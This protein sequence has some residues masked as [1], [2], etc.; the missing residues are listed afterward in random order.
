MRMKILLLIFSIFFIGS[1]TFVSAQ[2]DP[3]CKVEIQGGSGKMYSGQNAYLLAVVKGSTPLSYL[4][5][6]EGDIIKNYDDNVLG[7]SHD[8]IV[9]PPTPMSVE[10]FLNPSISFYWKPTDDKERT[11]SLVV[12]TSN[13]ECKTDRIINVEL[14]KDAKTQPEDFYVAQNH[15]LPGDTTN[16]LNQH[17][18]W[19]SEYR[20]WDE[21]YNDNGDLF[22]DFHRIY[23]EHFDAWRKEF[24]Y[25]NITIWDPGTPLPYGSDVD[26][27]SRGPNYIPN[28][29]PTWFKVQPSGDGPKDRDSTS[30]TCEEFDKPVSPWPSTQDAL[31]D[32]DPDLELLGCALTDPYHNDVHV[33]IDGDMGSTNAAPLD[34][35]FWRWHKFV[36]NIAVERGSLPQIN[37]FISPGGV[38]ANESSPPRIYYQNPF[39]LYPFITP[40]DLD[41]NLPKISI[42]FTEPVLG[43]NAS[44]VNNISATNVTGSEAGPYIFTGFKMPDFG[45]VNVTVSAGNIEDLNE[46]KF[47]GQSWTYQMTEPGKDNDKDGLSNEI[48]IKLLTDPTNKDTDNDTIADS[49]ETS[50]LCLNALNDDSQVMDMKGDIINSTGI[51]SDNDGITN[52]NE[53]KAN[54]DPCT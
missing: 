15:R 29:L 5:Q 34:P 40:N 39:R 36:D 42:V 50:H 54:Q 11:I 12:K 25:P 8:S 49:I 38:P 10:D 18:S 35:I 2:V 26:H 33:T 46:N 45:P 23:L 44:D 52:V 31:D 1:L 7:G 48:E 14:G 28:P 43:V 53:V 4:W 37:T 51:D 19:H 32:F 21:T 30:N 41:P 16:V 22:F 17:S 13:G 6:V 9:G 3:S 47:S 20:F 24:R 27:A